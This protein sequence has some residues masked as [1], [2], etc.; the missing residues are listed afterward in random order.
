M[1]GKAFAQWLVSEV[2]LVLIAPL[3]GIQFDLPLN[4]LV[5]LFISLVI[6]TPVLSLIGSIGAA[7]PA[8]QLKIIVKIKMA[9]RIG[10]VY[11]ITALSMQKKPNTVRG[12]IK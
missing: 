11:P 7:Q 3:I 1:L 8:G 10:S 2:P 12:L 5:I 4:T 9:M 6:G